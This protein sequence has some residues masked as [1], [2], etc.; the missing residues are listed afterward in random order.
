MGYLRELGDSMSMPESFA[1][2]RF[3]LAQEGV[4]PTA[5]RELRAGRKETH[6]MWF[7]FPQ[8]AGLGSSGMA[9]RYAIQS[10]EEAVVYLAHPVLGPRLRACAEALLQTSGRSAA[11]I[12]GYP[13]D[14]KLKSSM[15]LFAAVDGPDSIFI[16]VLDRF[17]NAERDAA[18]ERF[19]A[20]DLPS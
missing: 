12:L 5:L 20:R 7:I 8:V 17:Y 3:V 9:I 4:Y 2:E 18:T 1:L 13:D 14:V 6:W 11:D 16:A 19:L 15:T 10:R